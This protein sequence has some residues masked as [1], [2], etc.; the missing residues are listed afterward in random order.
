M[1][2]KFVR[3]CYNNENVKF[4]LNSMMS[5]IDDVRTAYNKPAI[6]NARERRQE[7]F[8]KVPNHNLVALRKSQILE[9]LNE[10]LK[11]EQ[12]T[13]LEEK[14]LNFFLLQL[15][16]NIRQGPILSLTWSAVD[17]MVEQRKA[18]T[19]TDENSSSNN[20]SCHS[21]STDP[22]EIELTNRHK[23]GYIDPVAL[24]IRNDQLPLLQHLRNNFKK[25]YQ[26]NPK[27]VFG[28]TVNKC[29][30]T[31]SSQ[32]T[33]VFRKFFGDD[34]AK[35]KFNSNSIRKYRDTRINELRGELSDQFLQSHFGQA[36]HC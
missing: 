35:F 31:A 32:V 5:A 28:N 13:Y 10:N 6:N 12:Y 21:G 8:K 4:D 14:T 36:A 17:Q 7:M 1:L 24:H 34:P 33:I 9:M 20:E 30:T 23:T 16:L 2:K 25:T 29:E 11:N 19:Q 18:K 3:H 15:R 27:Y 22:N 26:F